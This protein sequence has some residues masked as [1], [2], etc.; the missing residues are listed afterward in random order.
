MTFNNYLLF[1]EMLRALPVDCGSI[2]AMKPSPHNENVFV[3]C[4]IKRK[5]RSRLAR[6][7]VRVRF[8]LIFVHFFHF[9]SLY[10]RSRFAFYV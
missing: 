7:R 10:I 9:H 5:L 3:K 8:Q 6:C 1:F 2:M 4:T